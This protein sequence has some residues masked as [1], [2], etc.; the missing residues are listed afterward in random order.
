MKIANPV[1]SGSWCMLIFFKVVKGDDQEI[2]F[3]PGA[4]TWGPLIVF[5]ECSAIFVLE[6]NSFQNE[7]HSRIMRLAPRTQWCYL[8]P[9]TDS[10]VFS[11]VV[12]KAIAG[13]FAQ[14]GS[15]ML[16]VQVSEGGESSGIFP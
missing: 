8:M 15:E 1:V 4:K 16:E 11:L 12:S 6:Q 9:T 2:V 10:G 3:W 7:I 5:C 13:F 14:W